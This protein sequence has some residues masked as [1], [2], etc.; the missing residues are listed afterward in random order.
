MAYVKVAELSEVP[1]GGAKLVDL[2]GSPVALYNV[3]GSIHA[4]SNT[5]PH[6]GG[7]LAEGSLQGGVITCPWHRFEYDVRTGACKTKP[8]LRVACYSVRVE[9]QDILLEA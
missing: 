1:A 9:G 6:R 3:G 8:D 7:P 5:C 4:T 2:Q